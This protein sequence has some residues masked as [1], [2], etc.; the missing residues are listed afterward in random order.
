MLDG[1][2]LHKFA[3]RGR[4]IVPSG[5]GGSANN[6]GVVVNPV[7]AAVVE[8]ADAPPA[9]GVALPPQATPAE[10]A[11]TMVQSSSLPGEVEEGGEAPSTRRVRLSGR[12]MKD[13]DD[14]EEWSPQRRI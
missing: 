13:T 6:L 11:R 14:V 4:I 8:V 3:S 2:R 9:A 1:G 12:G 10:K 7:V 5:R